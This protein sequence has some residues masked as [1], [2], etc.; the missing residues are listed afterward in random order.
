MDNTSEKRQVV[1]DTSSHYSQKIETNKVESIN[2]N[3]SSIDSLESQTSEPQELKRSL[4]AR[5]LAVLYI[6]IL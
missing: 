1:D 6:I 5:H 4:K 3:G 2:E